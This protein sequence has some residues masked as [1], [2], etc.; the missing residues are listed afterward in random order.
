MTLWDTIITNITTNYPGV[1]LNAAR[2]FSS[3]FEILLSFMLVNSFFKP[4]LNSKIKNYDI[5]PFIILAVIVIFLRET[6]RIDTTVKY[7]I[8]CTALVAVLFACYDG[9]LKMKAIAS[10]L[11][12]LMITIS[13][14]AG[15]LIF[16][17]I[18]KRINFPEGSFNELLR[19]SLS[20][21]FMVLFAL[22]IS[23]FAKKSP[24][25]ALD[26]PL[27]I[28]LLIC[29][30]ITMVTFAVFQYYI[31]ISP[32]ENRIVRYI[33]I[34]GGGLIFINVIVFALFRKLE[35]QL[36]MKREND[37]LQSQLRL[38]ENSISNLENSYNRTRAF[39]H[40]IKNHILTM[41]MLAEQGNIDELKAYL[42]E[43][44]GV[45]DESAYVRISGISAVDAILNEKLYEAQSRSIT[46]NYDVI[47]LD[48]NSIKPMDLCIIL[49]NALDNAIEANEKIEN[50][51]E[52]F[53]KL[54]IHGNETFSVISVANPTVSTENKT[55]DV[56]GTVTA[57]K[58]KE[59]HG[60]GLRSIKSSVR[61][62]NGEMLCKTENGVFT[63][64]I[65][66]P[67]PAKQDKNN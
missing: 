43:M 50:E 33:Y 45:I 11:F 36:E 31:E 12:V 17:L 56:E 7:V 23:I 48:K 20:N 35:N 54:K 57:K 24:N 38:Q 14:S 4:R 18:S 39:R 29:P 6:D 34:S 25:Y 46:T 51:D 53:I 9:K 21:L 61:K 16:E 42:K 37:L 2:I 28:S 55:V 58:D 65:R 10:G 63:I 52:R 8:E 44:S 47:N 27:W 60:I 13:V 19:A 41:N 67:S 49:S 26:M 62:Y 66:L 40:D 3:V 32:P 59:N 64:V 15:S 1:L 5:L 22:L 30:V